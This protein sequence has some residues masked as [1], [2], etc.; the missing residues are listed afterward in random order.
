MAAARLTFKLNGTVNRHDSVYWAPENPHIRVDKAVS[1]PGIHVW[2][3]VST[4]GLVGPFLF[5]AT[6]TG[7]VYHEMLSTSILP[8]L[9]PMDF[10]LWGTVKDQVYRRKPHAH[11][12]NFA[13]KSQRQ[14]QR[15]PLKYWAK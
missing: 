15:S 6:V 14:V 12:N 11:W 7:E 8:D 2:R 9:T 10:Y 4:S 1:L 5:D 13:R 3:G